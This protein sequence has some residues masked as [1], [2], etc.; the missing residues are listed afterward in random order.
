MGRSVGENRQ[1]AEKDLRLIT[2]Y[3]R[4]AR[5]RT[6][7]CQEYNYYKGKTEAEKQ[8]FITYAPEDEWIEDPQAFGV[9]C[10]PYATIEAKDPDGTLRLSLKWTRKRHMIV[11]YDVPEPF[12]DTV[13][14]EIISDFTGTFKDDSGNQVVINGPGWSD[15]SGPAFPG[16]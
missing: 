2:S 1:T 10:P 3:K 9:K 14:Y 15:Y 4:S 13:T 16:S 11:Y 12:D 6:F 8:I 7:H 5:R